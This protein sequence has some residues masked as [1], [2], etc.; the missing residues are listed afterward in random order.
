MNDK[1]LSCLDIC[2]LHFVLWPVSYPSRV[3]DYRQGMAVSCPDLVLALLIEG[4]WL[5]LLPL[6][7]FRGCRVLIYYL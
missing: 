2:G 5:W 3:S 6:W 4:I 1:E 7:P